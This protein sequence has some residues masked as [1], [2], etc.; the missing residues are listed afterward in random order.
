MAFMNM[1]IL[2]FDM[3]FTAGVGTSDYE[4]VVKLRDGVGNDLGEGRIAQS[5]PHFEIGVMQQ[6]FLS[7]NFAFRLDIKNSFYNEKVVT[8][9]GGISGIRQTETSMK[10]NTMIT[11]GLTLFTN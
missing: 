2:Y 10:N 4:Q 6:L 11:F 3:G 9:D 8:Y 1:S 7:K 5:A